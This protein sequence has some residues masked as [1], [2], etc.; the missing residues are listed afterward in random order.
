MCV[1]VCVIV[2]MSVC[3]MDGKIVNRYIPRVRLTE[4]S[5]DY[6]VN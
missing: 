4:M 6:L 1:S 3:I 2:Y 5:L